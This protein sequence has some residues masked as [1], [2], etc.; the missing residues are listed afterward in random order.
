M[1]KRPA[2]YD[3]KRFP[4]LFELSQNWKIVRDEFNALEAPLMEINRVDK[5]HEEVMIEVQQYINSGNRYGWIQ[6]W[7][8]NGANRDWVQYGLITQD[9]P[10]PFIGSE[11]S[12]TLKM[13]KK[14]NGIKVGAL[15]TMFPQT[16]LPCHQHPEIF[17]EGLL[18][19]HLP[20]ETA[21][22]NNY[23]YLNVNGVF[24]QHICGKGLIFDGSLDHFALNESNKN[25]TILY[26]E[27]Y[28]DKLISAN[29]AD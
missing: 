7:G 23:A 8:K 13:L 27:F 28:K 2:F 6:G 4:L 17:S 14:I 3:I 5:A 24:R 22:N 10:F 19:F 18:Q 25:R 29:S 12:R 21:P 1:K 15:V 9:T 26:L 16:S 20:I 11:M